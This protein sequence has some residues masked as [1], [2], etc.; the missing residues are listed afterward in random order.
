MALRILVVEDD[1]ADFVLIEARVRQLQ[2]AEVLHAKTLGRAIGILASGRV[3]LILLD[4]GLPDMDGVGG[5]SQ[6]VEVCPETPLVVLTARSADD[7]IGLRA[8]RAGA[9][10]YLEKGAKLE[11]LNRSVR[12]SL[13][14]HRL[15]RELQEAKGKLEQQAQ[16]LNRLASHDPLTGL[17]NRRVLEHELRVMPDRAC[18]GG[19]AAYGLLFDLDDFKSINEAHGLHGGD[20]VLATVADSVHRLVR[21]SDVL[22]RIGGD[23]FVLLFTAERQNDAVAVAERLR[24]EIEH[25]RIGAPAIRVTASCALVRVDEAQSIACFLE[26]ARNALATSKNSGK[27]RI[28]VRPSTS[29]I[30]AQ[31]LIADGALLDPKSYRAETRSILDR[32]TGA[33]VA[34]WIAPVCLTRNGRLSDL[35]VAA[36][37]A[38]RDI[39]DVVGEHCIGALI[40]DPN[41]SSASWFSVLPTSIDSIRRL[42]EALMRRGESMGAIVFESGLLPRDAAALSARL[43]RSH[44]S[45][46][47]VV[48]TA[49][50]GAQFFECLVHLAPTY[51][52]YRAESHHRNDA[53]HEQ[54]LRRLVGVCG[55]LGIGV[56]SDGVDDQVAASGGAAYLVR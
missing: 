33:V 42:S 54:Q 38:E 11:A 20:E 25:L 3:D 5:V 31:A 19:E 4:L 22:A 23:E 43:K 16:E 8:I 6:L 50:V 15:V 9:Q 49:V 18:R 24:G 55:A 37:A 14:R 56:C 30:E 12:H 39:L 45:S 29:E 1:D 48:G 44:P 32:A 21:P 2:E 52:V 34:S 17:V 26:R 13:E 35:E 41:S 53:H 27:N 7:P 51:V 10:D 36:L 46:T 47:V 40:A 28:A